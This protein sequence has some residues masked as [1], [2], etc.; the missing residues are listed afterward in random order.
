MY[1]L[2]PLF[3]FWRFTVELQLVLQAVAATIL[4]KLGLK[5][6]QRVLCP[7]RELQYSTRIR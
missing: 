4:P 2:L 6:L 1:R 5:Y 7:L 3:F